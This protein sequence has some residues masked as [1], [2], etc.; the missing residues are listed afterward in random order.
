MDATSHVVLVWL[1]HLQA[2]IDHIP[3]TLVPGGV[4]VTPIGVAV[5]TLL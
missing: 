5:D 2:R 3:F 4:V 1:M